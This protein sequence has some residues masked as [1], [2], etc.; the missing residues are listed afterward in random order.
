MGNSSV[1]YGTAVG[2]LAGLLVPRVDRSSCIPGVAT[3]T[4]TT[5]CDGEFD[6]NTFHR[7][8]RALS[9]DKE[10]DKDAPKVLKR[11][12]KPP[13]VVRAGA[14][15]RNDQVKYSI[16]QTRPSQHECKQ[17]SSSPAGG[18]LLLRNECREGRIVVVKNPAPDELGKI[19]AEE[20][21]RWNHD[22]PARCLDTL[23]VIQRLLERPLGGILLIVAPSDQL[24][25]L[26]G[27]N[28]DRGYMEEKLGCHEGLTSVH[29]NVFETE[30]Q[31][32]RTH[33]EGDRDETGRCCDGAFLIS[34]TGIVRRAMV[35]CK[36]GI[37][38]TTWPDKGTRH[39][40]AIGVVLSLDCCVVFVASEAGGVHAIT[41]ESARRAEAYGIIGDH[42]A[43]SVID[44]QCNR[45]CCA[46]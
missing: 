20:I 30:L 19:F 15:F 27:Q 44:A 46:P 8:D 39:D 24:K 28:A 29:D 23:F 9:G 13:K 11:P 42:P 26:E 45:C 5:R 25:M 37:S 38:D 6:P 14:A 2:D 12:G 32:A 17:R 40:A 3:E 16:L 31:A 43:H 33:K 10:L 7:K 18:K 21:A 4:Y 36:Y 1:T 34:A 41:A 35:K 22:D